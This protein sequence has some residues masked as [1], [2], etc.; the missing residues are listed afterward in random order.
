ML[1]SYRELRAA[2]R[3]LQSVLDSNSVEEIAELLGSEPS[4]ISSLAAGRDFNDLHYR[5]FFANLGFSDNELPSDSE[6]IAA[7]NRRITDKVLRKSKMLGD[8]RVCH[9]LR[10]QFSGHDRVVNAAEVEK[11]LVQ[12]LGSVQRGMDL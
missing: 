6:I 1:S 11:A 12:A 7:I 2:S 8:P 10:T 4:E 9:A 3:A 5:G